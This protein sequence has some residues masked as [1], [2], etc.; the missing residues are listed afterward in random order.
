MLNIGETPGTISPSIPNIVNEVNPMKPIQ[1]PRHLIHVKSLEIAG[2][3]TS[4]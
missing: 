4:V 3:L 2:N 1:N